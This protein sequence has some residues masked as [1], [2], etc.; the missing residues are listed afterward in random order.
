MLCSQ[1]ATF[2]RLKPYHPSNPRDVAMAANTEWVV[3]REGPAGRVLLWAHNAHVSKRPIEG[4][5]SP[6]K[7]PVPS[8]GVL[9]ARTLGSG[10]RAIGTTYG[11]TTSDSLPDPSSIDAALAA[12]DSVPFW[13]PLDRIET[14]PPAR[15]WL[16]TPHPIQFQ[17]VGLLSIVPRSAY[18][19]LVFFPRI[20]PAR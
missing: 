13:I 8:M 6:V 4:P 1:Q 15:R 5:A 20:H 14:S 10:Y 18:D 11:R 17:G 7:T 19:V 3:H 9:L 12:V 16:D 2:L